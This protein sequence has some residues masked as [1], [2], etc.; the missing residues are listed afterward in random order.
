MKKLVIL[1]VLSLSC[2]LAF[3]SAQVLA[4][5]TYKI[6]AALPLTGPA[7]F[8]GEAERE[9][10]NMAVDQINAAGG[11][12]GQMLEV[13]YMDTKADVNTAQSV[14]EKLINKNNV[15][16]IITTDSNSAVGTMD[17]TE[18]AQVVHLSVARADAFTAKG[19]GYCFRNQ[20]TNQMLMDQYM[21]DLK[22]HLNT[23]KLAILVANYPYGLS[24]LDGLKKAKL[25]D[26][27][28]V[29]ENKFPME[30][31]DFTP[32]LTSIKGSGADT[33]V[34]ICVE[35]HAIGVVT[36]FKELGLDK[37]GIRL[38]GDDHVV[39]KAVLE[40][41]GEKANGVYAQLVYHQTFN[42]AAEDFYRNYHQKFGKYPGSILH[43]LGYGNV[44]AI[45]YGL[46]TAGTNTDNKA[47]ADALRKIKYDSPLGTNASF[48]KSGQL[49]G[50]SGRLAQVVDGKLEVDPA[51]WTQ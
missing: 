48:D 14:V 31:A 25:A 23:K 26:I 22:N 12:N 50:A 33:I 39:E 2:C 9:T 3:P 29:Y 43:A 36:K 47:L 44:Y 6:G 11:V 35:R 51:K 17:I 40:A 4:A 45:Y 38:A 42:P 1:L 10:M 19:Y 34:L 15:P 28:I 46:Q 7:Q 32:Y 13:I 49:Q 30:T 27:D 16:V 41:V 5:D 18:R 37:A 21:Q 8:L 24:A 20:P